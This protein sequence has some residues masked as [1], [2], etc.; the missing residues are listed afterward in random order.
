MNQE[1]LTNFLKQK[2]QSLLQQ[3]NQIGS[4]RPKSQQK[5]CNQQQTLLRPPSSQIQSINGAVK[6]KQFIH[7]KNN[8]MLNRQSQ[9]QLQYQQNE[10]HNCYEITPQLL[11]EISMDDPIWK[12]ILPENLKLD[13]NQLIQLLDENTD[14]FYHNL[15]L[16]A[17]FKCT[18]GRCKC[19]VTTQ[20]KL[21]LN[22]IFLTNYDKDFVIN[23]KS[24]K[25]V[26]NPLNQKTYDTK[27]MDQKS[28]NLKSLYQQDFQQQPL[29]LQPNLKKHSS[30][31]IGSV[32]NLT[33]YRSNYNDWGTNYHKFIPYPHISTSPDIKFIGSSQYKDSYISP[34]RWNINNAHYFKTC[35]TP[36]PTGQF[37]G[38]TTHKTSFIPYSTSHKSQ[39]DRQN[40][41]EKIPTFEGQ[42]IS[43][44]MNDYIK[45]DDQNCPA[46]Q[47]QKIFRK[48]MADKL[49]K[50]QQQF[51][52]NQIQQ[53]N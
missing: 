5:Y 42:F 26:T 41:Y 15:K 44:E 20:V 1:S 14:Y 53:N 11:S 27:F 51:L 16:C 4:Y 33:S 17:C 52:K 31:Q 24:K 23:H 43:T 40:V 37:E 2:P 46:K 45:K 8:L 32:S 3:N 7:K 12:R 29:E 48:Q 13:E 22:G 50:K 21:K 25:S 39:I 47:F 30:Q 35:L 49:L 28:I 38:Q 36:I 18:C 9:T 10:D 6:R 34:N 19:D